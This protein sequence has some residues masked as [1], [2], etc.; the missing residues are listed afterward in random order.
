MLY[1]VTFNPSLDY[2]VRV[3]DF[4]LGRT[5]R[6][7]TECLYP[8]G[9]GINVSLVLKSLGVESTALG[10]LAGFTGDEIRRMLG[11]MGIRTDFLQLPEGSSRINVK[12][13]DIEG[14]EINGSGPEI[15]DNM[16]RALLEKLDA[17]GPGDTLVLA[18]SIPASLPDDIYC[19]ILTP[20]TDKGVQTV[21]DASG[22]LLLRVLPHRPFLI[23]P[24]H[25]ELG[26]LFGTELNSRE[27]VIPYAVKLREQGAQNVLVSLAGQGAVLAAA[28]GRIYQAP[29]PQGRLINGVGAGDSMVAGFLA[30]W[31]ETKSWENAFRLAVAAGSASAFA[32]HFATREDILTL[33]DKVALTLMNL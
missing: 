17:L 9:K 32:E 11:K 1:T 18:G 30:S 15:P 12:L 31:Q 29:A 13:L 10:Y 4:R 24:N 20:L 6:T 2:L 21:V 5:N 8:G 22:D 25:R 14:T 26:A 33:Y 16:V 3:P 19:R 27:A 23:K 7:Q 28:D